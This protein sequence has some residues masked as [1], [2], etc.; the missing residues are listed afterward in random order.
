[1]G[2]CLVHYLTAVVAVSDFVGSGIINLLSPVGVQHNWVN[3]T[4]R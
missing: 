4:F 2:F 3:K 1:M